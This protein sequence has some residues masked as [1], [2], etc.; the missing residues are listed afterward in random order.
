[1]RDHPNLDLLSSTL[2]HVFWLGDL[3]YRVDLKREEVCQ[4][5]EDK[6]FGSLAQ[7][8]QLGKAIRSGK[9]FLG[10]EEGELSFPP[11]YRFERGSR[12]YET[13]KMRVPSYTD[14]VLWHTL[15]GIASPK[16]Q[17]YFSVDSILTSD[18]NPVVALFEAPLVHTTGV[19]KIEEIGEDVSRDEGL[20]GSPSQGIQKHA[21]SRC[22][23]G[24]FEDVRPSF[25]L[26]FTKLSCRDLPAMDGTTQFLLSKLGSSL[27]WASPNASSTSSPTSSSPDDDDIGRGDDGG[28]SELGHPCLS[29]AGGDRRFPVTPVVGV[30]AG[31][32]ADDVGTDSRSGSTS[33]GVGDEEEEEQDDAVVAV[34]VARERCDPYCVFLG[35]AVA[36]LQEGEYRSAVLRE[37]QNPVWEPCRRRGQVPLLWLADTT[38]AVVRRRHLTITVMDADAGATDD[39]VGSVVVWLGAGWQAEA[40]A[41]AGIEAE[42]AQAEGRTLCAADDAANV[43]V[44][45]D[46]VV[47]TAGFELPILHRGRR[48]G[49]LRGHYNIRDRRRKRV[50]VQ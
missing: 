20:D 15:P 5:V 11:T 32:N 29:P 14:R 34:R 25:V 28:V 30:S 43:D 9:A 41:A 4:L 19:R 39:V 21:C 40:A 35:D 7:A 38:A 31:S 37:T 1:L 23:W 16:L 48:R 47:A 6:D 26:E 50:C 45:D 24:C 17:S 27:S 10:F 46:D 12:K 13:T 33:D 18:H 36:E 49:W 22:D 44:D 42:E 8:D 2:H 3:N